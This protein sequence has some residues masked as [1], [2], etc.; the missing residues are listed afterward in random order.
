MWRSGNWTPKLWLE[1]ASDA[2]RV[3]PIVN[4]FFLV[5]PAHYYTNFFFILSRQLSL[6]LFLY[7]T[8]GSFD[9]YLKKNGPSRERR[10][11]PGSRFSRSRR[12]RKRQGHQSI[13]T[14]QTV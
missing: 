7:F 11:F 9:V 2:T 13:W 8:K 1:Q 4:F 12:T 6:F 14:Q 5:E 10:K 3:Y